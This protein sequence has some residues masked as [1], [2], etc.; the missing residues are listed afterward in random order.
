MNALEIHHI[1]T[2]FTIQEFFEYQE[3]RLHEIFAKEQN[4]LRPYCNLLLQDGSSI[5]TF[6]DFEDEAGKL[7]SIHRIKLLSFVSSAIAY[8]GVYEAFMKTVAISNKDYNVNSTLGKNFNYEVSM[9]S[10]REDVL[11]MITEHKENEGVISNFINWKIEKNSTGRVLT[12]RSN[13][14]RPDRII[15]RVSGIIIP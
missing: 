10:D 5:F 2:N 8:A 4:G 3:E 11:V 15:G 6:M 14:G 9:M 7:L 13:L 1:E 12:N